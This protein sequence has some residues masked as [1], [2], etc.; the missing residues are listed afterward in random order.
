MTLSPILSIFPPSITIPVA[1]SRSFTFAARNGAGD[2]QFR[3]ASGPG[4]ITAGGE[5]TA[6][7]GGGATVLEVRDRS[8]STATASVNSVFTRT[9]GPVYAAVSDGTNWYLGG[10]FSAVN[11]YEAPGLAA[12]RT[13]DATTNLACD[14]QLG[15]DGDVLAV[16]SDGTTLYVGGRFTRYRQMATPGGLVSL[17][18]ATC[19]PLQAFFLETDQAVETTALALSGNALY[20]AA[21]TARYRGSPVASSMGRALIKVQTANAQ[22]THEFSPGILVPEL[23]RILVTPE[24]LYAGLYKLDPVTGAK[25]PAFQLPFGSIINAYARL[26]NVLYVGGSFDPAVGGLLKVDASTGVVDPQFPAG[27]VIDGLV[28]DMALVGNSLYIIGYFQHFGSTA[29]AGLAKIDAAT[30]ALD[31]AFDPAVPFSGP[32]APDGDGRAVI[33]VAGSIYAAGKVRLPGNSTSYRVVRLNA[34]TGAMDTGFLQ[35]MGFNNLPRT[36]CFAGGNVYAGGSFGTYGGIQASNLAKLNISTGVA[37]ASF[38]GTR[39]TNGRIAS[40]VLKAGALYIGGDFTAFDGSAVRNLVKVD[41]T[42]ASV[43]PVF[44]ANNSGTGLPVQALAADA[45]GLFVGGAFHTYRD[46]VRFGLVKVS[47]VDGVPIQNF[48]SGFTSPAV[49]A[50]AF[51]GNH[52]YVNS[53]AQTYA[54]HFNPS[55]TRID[56]I[57]GEMDTS[58]PAFGLT[59]AERVAI[60]FSEDTAFASVGGVPPGHNDPSSLVK[61]RPSTGSMDPS[62]YI[63]QERLT[64]PV[65]ALRIVNRALYAAATVTQ[66]FSL[67]SKGY[68]LAKLDPQTGVVDQSFSQYSS[69]VNGSIRVIE[70]TGSDLWIGGEFTRFR[71]GRGSYF[72]PVNPATGLAGDP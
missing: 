17:E 40:M 60:T 47:L 21:R 15:F 52:L 6:G 29:R 2:Y 12:L 28:N 43:D 57:S 19:K 22:I 14:L 33:E 23:Q 3:V 49:H 1:S 72:I 59:S 10:L 65:Y 46:V 55:L 50:M 62:F 69:T 56:A 39:G 5:F 41:A 26:G 51:Y 63:P 48:T 61:F 37:D 9:N 32:S 58:F 8:G 25:D 31:L 54:N 30:G 4:T 35:P 11:A 42:T 13:A 64:A 36:L 20:V 68:F 66:L 44:N 18:A 24:A 67:D 71:G 34:T 45:I 16:V 70:S 38:T 53:S 27:R 7:T